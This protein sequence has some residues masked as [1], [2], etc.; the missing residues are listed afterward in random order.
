MKY[1]LSWVFTAGVALLLL[2]SCSTMKFTAQGTIV[3]D[4]YTRTYGAE[5]T[6]FHPRINT[7]L[8]DYA[9]THK[10]NAFQVVRLGG[11]AVV[12][13]GRYKR[14]GDAGGF[15]ATLTAKPSGRQKTAVQIK[16]SSSNPE[17]P[18]ESLE[19]AADGLFRIVEAGT[20]VP[21]GN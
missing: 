15:F 19:S 17:A 13:Q 10:G 9:R 21:A 4:T 7:A 8:Q 18:G 16:I 3:K 11:D 1:R 2:V 6:S 12:I 5:F 14:N 20:G